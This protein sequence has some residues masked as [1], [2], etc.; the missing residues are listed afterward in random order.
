MGASA[1]TNN[2]GSLAFRL[3]CPYRLECGSLFRQLPNPS[4]VLAP[5]F[6]IAAATK[7]YLDAT[8]TNEDDLLGRYIFD[9]FPDNPD[10]P[11]ANG[12]AG[13]TASLERVMRSK[14]S[15]HMGLQRYDI[16]T[17]ENGFAL[18]Y[19][20]PV[21]API[22]DDDG[23]LRWI[24]HEVEDVTEYVRLKEA[25]ND[26]RLTDERLQWDLHA[27][28][29]E[30]GQNVQALRRELQ[31]ALE[32]SEAKTRLLSAV[33]HDLRQPAQA[34]ELFAGCLKSL[35][36]PEGAS[37]RIRMIETSLGAMDRMLSDLLD[38][39]RLEAGGVRP[40]VVPFCLTGLLERLADEFQP[41]A[42]AKGLAF[43]YR[44]CP[45][46]ACSDPVL[47][48]QILRNLITNAIKYTAKGAVVLLCRKIGREVRVSVCDT[49]IG[50]PA[51]Q[52]GPIFEDYVQ[53]K[54]TGSNPG[55]LGIG[56]AT[57]ARTAKLLGH[58]LSVR[59]RQGHGSIF[60]IRLP[61]A[62]AWSLSVR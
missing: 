52:T 57:V 23:A 40:Q 54:T 15:D 27:I 50:I 9:A 16:P 49:G 8:M 22:L 62:E 11:E 36:L 60:S 1:T 4:L 59:S 51:D 38:L 13:L 47:L 7:T 19:W 33:C 37:E 30:I 41:L 34:A 10:A 42:E 31:T 18:R 53:L 56:L 12:V 2:R 32:A 20:L 14:T 45:F 5:D 44:Y 29:T 48:E 24:V 58:G 35:P 55:G 39:S 21:N 28:K 25:A 26:A 6:S 46:T 61:S 17:R 43:K 3:S